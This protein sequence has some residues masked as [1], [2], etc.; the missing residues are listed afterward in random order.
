MANV[1]RRLFLFFF[2]VVCLEFIL[3][4]IYIYTLFFII[5]PSTPR[6]TILVLDVYFPKEFKTSLN[7]VICIFRHYM[8]QFTGVID[9]WFQAD[10]K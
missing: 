7:K 2:V 6:F 1:S 10:A 3:Y 8:T 5:S 9:V 4:N